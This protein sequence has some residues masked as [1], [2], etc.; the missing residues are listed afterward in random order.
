MCDDDS[1]VFEGTVCGYSELLLDGLRKFYSAIKDAETRKAMRSFF[2]SSVK[3][4][5]GKIVAFGFCS[6]KK[7]FNNLN[8]VLYSV[9]DNWIRYTVFN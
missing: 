8:I 3:I 1:F 6:T 4:E 9:G 7:V 2:R 5:E